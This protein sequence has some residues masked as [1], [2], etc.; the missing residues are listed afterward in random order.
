M[1]VIF[2]FEEGVSEVNRERAV[3]RPEIPA[4]RMMIFFG[5]VEVVE[6]MMSIVLDSFSRL[7]LILCSPS[8]VCCC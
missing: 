1:I 8:I 3:W 7:N 6:F 2:G 4:P 5:M